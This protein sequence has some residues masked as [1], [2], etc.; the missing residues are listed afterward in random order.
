ML[1]AVTVQNH[2]QVFVLQNYMQIEVE[3]Q[4]DYTKMKSA[5]LI[6]RCDFH[7]FNWRSGQVRSGGIYR[8][9]ASPRP[10][11]DC[12]PSA[13]VWPS[14]RQ[15]PGP[16]CPHPPDRTPADASMKRVGAPSAWAAHRHSTRKNPIG[17]FLRRESRHMPIE[18]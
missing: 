8:S 12:T 3:M 17:G 1:S 16:P 15:T 10:T 2:I 11:C 14:P 9:S 6:I 7:H 13:S 4:I 18:A 5:S